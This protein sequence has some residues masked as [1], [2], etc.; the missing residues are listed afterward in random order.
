[1]CSNSQ[2]IKVLCHWV[3]GSC[4]F[5]SWCKE[6]NNARGVVQGGLYGGGTKH[7]WACVSRFTGSVIATYKR[8]VVGDE[9]RSG[10]FGL[11]VVHEGN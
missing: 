3:S 11:V 5:P 4:R 6:D 7:I 8:K 2:S 9:H 1:M 10:C